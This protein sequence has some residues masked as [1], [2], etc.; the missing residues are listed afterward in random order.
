MC[1]S[2]DIIRMIKERRIRWFGPTACMDGMRN[3]Q[4]TRSR[5][6][7]LKWSG[8]KWTGFI[9]LR[10]ERAEVSYVHGNKC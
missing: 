1:T 10:T 2:P 8:V 4:Q 6:R 9:W 7:L 3:A 5:C